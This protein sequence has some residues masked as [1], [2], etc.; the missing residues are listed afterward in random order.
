S[1]K[2][3]VTSY[4]QGRGHSERILRMIAL[5]RTMEF[6]VTRSEIEALL[7]EANLIKRLRPR[8]N[9]LL[10]DDK[11]Y[12]YI[13]VTDDRPAPGLFKH[14]GARTHKGRYYGPFASAGAVTRTIN[15]LQRAFLI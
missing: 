3:R 14:R 9:V 8:F 12:P 6:I 7:L 13:L 11:S 1:L 15:A 5:T 2:K 10:R 4:A